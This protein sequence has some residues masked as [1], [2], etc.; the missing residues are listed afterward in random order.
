MKI[1]G[2]VG[3]LQTYE[4]SLPLVKKAKTIV[5]MESKKKVRVSSEEGSDNEEDALAILAK[6]F[7][8]LMKDDKFKKKFTED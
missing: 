2:L 5:L 6:N 8:R 4:Y 3:S 7:R 1:E